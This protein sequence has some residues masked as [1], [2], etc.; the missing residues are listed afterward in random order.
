MNIVIIGPPGSGKGTQSNLIV[1]NYNLTLVSLGNILR[2]YLLTNKNKNFLLDKEVCAGNL[3][4]D[5]ISIK[6]LKD[7]LKH[8]SAYKG[9]LIDGFPRNVNQAVFLNKIIKLNYIIE[10]KI[11][12]SVI[13][14]RLLGR[15]IHMK[16]GRVYHYK[17]NPPKLNNLD[18]ITGEKLVVRK[19]DNIDSIKRRLYLY[20]KNITLIR[21]YFKFIQK[22]VLKKKYYF[23][24]NAEDNIKNISN[25]ISSIIKN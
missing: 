12:N 23:V 2:N 24:I 1:K 21:N 13:Y 16:S 7:Y 8:N 22:S 5:D 20:N 25:K 17:Y 9:Y 11:S 6:I 19:D 18:D 3:V 15:Q 10:L 4:S 14:K